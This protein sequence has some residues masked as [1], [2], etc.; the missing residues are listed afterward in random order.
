MAIRVTEFIVEHTEFTFSKTKILP[1]IYTLCLDP[2]IE[3]RKI[4]LVCIYKL[5]NVIDSD[6]VLLTLEKVKSLGTDRAIN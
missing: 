4:S 3:V 1:R 2:N 5:L 6:V